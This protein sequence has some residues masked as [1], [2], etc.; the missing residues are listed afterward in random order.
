MSS[1]REKIYLAALLHDIGKFYQRADVGSVANSKY[2]NQLNKVESTFLPQRNGFYS[3]KHCLWTAQ[4]IDDN[5]S[6]FK[7][8]LNDD[9]AATYL[10][11]QDN[12]YNLAARHHLSA[13]QL[14]DLGKIIKEADCLSSGMDRD[15]VEAFKDDQDESSWDSFNNMESSLMQN[16]TNSSVFSSIKSY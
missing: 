16:V 13:D 12:F 2:L 15:S 9:N 11:D 8:L 10:T 5:I 14:S 6:V 4:F 1:N 7:T 3:H